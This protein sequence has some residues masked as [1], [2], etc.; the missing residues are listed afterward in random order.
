[1]VCRNAIRHEVGNPAQYLSKGVLSYSLLPYYEIRIGC[2][3]LLDKGG[4]EKNLTDTPA[5][6]NPPTES[7]SDPIVLI[8]W[9][10]GYPYFWTVHASECSSSINLLV[11]LSL[12]EGTR[13]RSL[14]LTTKIWIYWCLPP[15]LSKPTKFIFARVNARFYVWTCLSYLVY[16]S[17]GL[18][19]FLLT[20][21]IHARNLKA[22]SAHSFKLSSL[23]W[24]EMRLEI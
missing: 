14:S 6:L 12:D 18:D 11:C 13:L 22:W 20:L 8:T 10:S 21:E 19:N 2:W 3:S 17:S 23:V 7:T 4:L 5:D 15:V 1:M 16:R 24:R 9:P